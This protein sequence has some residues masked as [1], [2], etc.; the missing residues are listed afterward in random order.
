MV[1]ALVV[2]SNTGGFGKP[3]LF[4]EPQ[5]QTIQQLNQFGFDVDNRVINNW[6]VN[7]SEINNTI[8]GS[9]IPN[10]AT[11]TD[12]TV[13]NSVFFDGAGDTG[14][15]WN[16]DTSILKVVGCTQLDNI[17]ICNNTIRAINPASIKGDVNILPN[18]SGQINLIGPT[19]IYSDRGDFNVTMPCGGSTVT[20]LDDIIIMSS[21]GSILLHSS[22]YVSLTSGSLLT[23]GDT[24]NS[25]SNPLDTQELVIKS[26]GD[27]VVSSDSLTLDKT[28]LSFDTDKSTT[29]SKVDDNLEITNNDGDINITARV[30]DGSVNIFGNTNF[31]GGLRVLDSLQYNV[32]KYIMGGVVNTGN[33]RPDIVV[34]MFS[35]TGL[36]H[37]VSGTMP[38]L[39]VPDG[40]VIPDGSLKI[41]V[42]QKMD[43]GCSYTLHFNK[44]ITPNPPTLANTTQTPPPYA[45]KLIFRRQ[46]QS[47]QLI[48][49]AEDNAWILLT[50]GVYAE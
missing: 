21:E 26:C 20:A 24:C 17:E 40:T 27:V 3:F 25:I 50:A 22:E 9:E 2:S 30:P 23:F 35:V 14:V 46:S 32:D 4:E 19:E 41:L 29:I 44:L 37:A 13:T 16:A 10:R 47:A 8:I 31:G 49:D 48:Y 33:P 11:F 38:S 42:C 43:T 45:T 18:S 34:S 15:V 12:I 28:I 36:S 7:N 39:N 1:K 6:Y 5:A